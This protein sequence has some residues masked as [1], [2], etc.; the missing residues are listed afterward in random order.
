MKNEICHATRKYLI[1]FDN[2][3]A[4][5]YDRIIPALASLIDRKFGLHRN[6]VFVHATTLKETKY[7]LKTSLGVSEE[8]YENCEAYPIDGTGQGSGNSPAIWC[9]VSSILY[10]CHQENVHGAYFCTPDQH[11]SVSLGYL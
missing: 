4:S 2:D 3:T 5:C 8:F 10:F 6:V 7:K 11:L 9:I 1:N